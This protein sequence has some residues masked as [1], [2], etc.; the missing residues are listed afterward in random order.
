MNFPFYQCEESLDSILRVNPSI[1]RELFR[2][3]STEIIQESVAVR[4]APDDWID[5][6]SRVP[7]YKLVV[8]QA[9]YRSPAIIRRPR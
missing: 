3:M 2:S 7:R 8:S 5:P 4:G 9:S 1:T 6:H